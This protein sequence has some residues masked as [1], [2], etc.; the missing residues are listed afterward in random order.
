MQKAGESYGKASTQRPLITIKLLKPGG[1][2]S[3]RAFRFEGPFFIFF[4]R[5]NFL[6]L[7]NRPNAFR[8]KA[9]RIL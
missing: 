9:E 6:W 5:K 2:D 7:N 3:R 4:G 1:L 8:L